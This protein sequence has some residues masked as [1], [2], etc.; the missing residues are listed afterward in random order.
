M[1]HTLAIQ[2]KLPDCRTTCRSQADEIKMIRTPGEM[3]M[4]I[5]MPRMEERNLAARRRI[6]GM[7]LIGF[8]AVAALTGER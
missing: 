6:E 2:I 7:R 4:P 1:D 3:L 8:G 5:V